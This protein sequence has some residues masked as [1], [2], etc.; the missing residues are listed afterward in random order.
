MLGGWQG[1]P[2]EG[3]MGMSRMR[4]CALTGCG[5]A[6]G[7]VLAAGVTCEDTQGAAAARGHGRILEHG[8]TG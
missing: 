1:V 7:H 8:G 6:A 4:V 5:T 2:R 3:P